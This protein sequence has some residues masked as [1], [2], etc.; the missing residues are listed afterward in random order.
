MERITIMDEDSIAVKAN[1]SIQGI[2]SLSGDPS[3]V[4]GFL[5]HSIGV[6]PENQTKIL[7]SILILVVLGAIRFAILRVV[8][9][10]T[11]DPKSRYTWRRSVSF[12]VGFLTV[13]LIGSVW[14]KAIGQFGALRQR[15]DLSPRS[16]I[17]FGHFTACVAGN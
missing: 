2:Y 11:E 7:Y 13:I 6:S 17:P 3:E 5:E 12:I 14:I 16:P 8:W 9:K 1:D 4:S 10:F 15:S